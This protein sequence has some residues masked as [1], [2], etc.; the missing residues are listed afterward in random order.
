MD[1]LLN[2]LNLD[3]LNIKELTILLEVLENIKNKTSKPTEDIE[4]I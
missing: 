1:N 3:E 2:N 4:V